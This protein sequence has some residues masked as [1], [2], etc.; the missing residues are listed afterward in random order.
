MAGVKVLPSGPLRSLIETEYPTIRARGNG[1]GVFFSDVEAVAFR[2][3]LSGRTIQRV[4]SEDEM[5]TLDV[6]DNICRGLTSHL[7][8]VY[9]DRYLDL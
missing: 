9:G 3:G 2:S 6:A 8:L 7:A 4:M 1:G 5:V